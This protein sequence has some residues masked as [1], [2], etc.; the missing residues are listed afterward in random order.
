MSQ[1]AGSVLTP[2]S[3][4]ETVTAFGDGRDITVLAGGTILM[5]A[6]SYGRYPTQGVT[7]MLHEAGLDGISGTETVRVGATTTLAELAA[8]DLEPLSSA[9]AEVADGEIR[10]QATVGGNVC[11]PPGD[12][13]R[14]DLRVPLL[15]LDAE[16]DCV[17][18]GQRQ[19]E[20]IATFLARDEPRLALAFEFRRPTRSAYLAQRRP[21]AHSYAVAAVACAE[22]DGAVRVAASG[23][24]RG[25]VRLHA[26]EDALAG[27]GGA[28][29]AA[30]TGEDLR[31]AAD[32]LASAWYREQLIPVLVTRVLQQMQGGR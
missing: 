28:D 30:R 25:A 17:V 23:D 11:A 6:V 16:V 32:V 5:P 15:V 27:G 22:L 9:A 12:T 10:A 20:P 31:P 19:T 29:V 2:A 21:H 1:G 8:A 24:E 4:A 7:V 26:V 14:G 18:S 13:P 3:E